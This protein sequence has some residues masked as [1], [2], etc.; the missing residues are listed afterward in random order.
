MRVLHTAHRLFSLG[1]EF[2]TMSKKMLIDAAHPEEIRVVITDENATI[3]EF[4]FTTA[5]KKQIKGNVYLA[6]VT[7]VEPS[8]QAAFVE[9]GGNKQGFLPFSEI[10]PDYYQIPVS[11]RQKLIEE[12]EKAAAE[13]EKEEEDFDSDDSDDIADETIY[14]DIAAISDN[15][16]STDDYG[17]DIAADDDAPINTGADA[18]L[19]PDDTNIENNETIASNVVASPSVESEELPADELSND[20]TENSSGAKAAE[21]GSDNDSDNTGA[22]SESGNNDNL[23]DD[24]DNGN[25]NSDGVKQISR[26][27]KRRRRPFRD[28][29]NNNAT[30]DSDEA[31][32]TISSEDEVERPKRKPRYSRRYKIQ[33]V[34]KRNQILLVQITKEERGNKGVSLSTFMSLAGRYCVLMPNSPRSGGISRKITNREDRKKL[35]KVISELKLPKG[36]SVIVRTAGAGRTRAEIKRDFDYLVKL[37]NEIRETTLISSAPALIYEE[38][39]L[40]KRTIR[41]SYNSDIDEILV[42]GEQTYKEAKAFMRMLVPSHAPKVKQHKSSIPLFHQYNIEEQLLSMYDPVVKLKSGGYLVLN[43]TEALISI[44]VNS[45]RSTTERNVEETATKTNIEAAKEIARQL[46][47]RDLAGL[48]VIDFIDMLDSKNR[49][50]VERCLK[51]ALRNDKARIQVG[52]ISP[53]GLLEMSRQRL[54]PSIS[55]SVNLTCPHCSGNG[56]IRSDASVAIQII[57]ELERE[58]STGSTREF[59][60]WVTPSVAIYL[61]NHMHDDIHNIQQD[62]GVTVHIQIG[63]DLKLGNFRIEKIKRKDTKN[64]ENARNAKTK[65]SDSEQAASESS[66]KTSKRGSK[67]SKRSTLK[68]NGNDTNPNIQTNAE[69]NTDSADADTSNISSSDEAT[70]SDAATNISSQKKRRGRKRKADTVAQQTDDADYNSVDNNKQSKQADGKATKRGRRKKTADSENDNQK[71]QQKADAKDSSYTDASTDSHQNSDNFISVTTATAADTINNS[72]TGYTANTDGNNQNT[73]N[74]NSPQS[75]DTASN[76]TETPQPTKKPRRKGWWQKM[77]E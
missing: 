31:I 66:K 39:N 50:K 53:F 40:V 41:D 54:R 65:R 56:Y 11:D 51:E 23:A 75:E 38:S 35:K 63:N 77:V 7:R 61:L 37:W 60:V 48:I 74:N 36:M 14:D 71:T 27:R 34:I 45:G 68:D 8:L 67:K 69:H 49:R 20:N 43:P 64:K 25:N 13:E 22:Y 1:L 44:D 28:Y 6:K 12:E 55:E 62:M 18:N 42:E 70:N 15:E 52:R 30:S 24:G 47:L 2:P 5:A 76:A 19:Q 73:A 32:E 21:E 9:Y 33:E 29:R 72:T 59:K 46:K 4:D 3:Y 10:H 58:A 57:R 17:S 16:S 26:K